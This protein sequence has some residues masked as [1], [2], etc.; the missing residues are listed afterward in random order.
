MR[1]ARSPAATV[2]RTG[3]SSIPMPPLRLCIL[4]HAHL[5]F[6]RR[7]EY[8]DPFEER[9]L[10]EAVAECYLPLLDAIDGW[11]RDGV[12]FGLTVSIS[13]TLA[14]MLDDPLLRSRCARRLT[15]S[16]E[17][18]EKE[19]ARTESD[20]ALAPLARAARDRAERLLADYES[21]WRRDVAG[22]F[23]SF[24]SAGAAG[25]IE[26]AGTCATH[27]FLPLMEG[28]PAAARAQTRIGARTHRDRFGAAPSGFWL[29]ECGFYP[30]ADALVAETG[31]R[32]F[33][34]DAHGLLASDPPPDYGV[35]VPCRSPAG[36]AIFARELRASRAV[37]DAKSGYPG[38]GRYLE[39]HRDVGYDLDADYLAPYIHESG[40]RIATGIKYRAIGSRD[41]PLGE[42]PVYDPEAAARAVA[43]HAAHFVAERVALARELAGL[44]DRPPVAVVPF[45]AELFGHWW[46]EGPAFLDAV[47]RGVA[48]ESEVRAATLADA[49]EASLDA[50][51]LPEAAPKTS[52]WGEGGFSAVWLD[53]SNAWIRPELDGAAA[54]F[55]AAARERAGT[56][57]PLARRA[58][59][60]AARELLLAQA[61]DWPFMIR[62]GTTARYAEERVREHVAAVRRTSLAAREGTVEEARLAAIEARDN[63]FP[64][65]EFEELSDSPL[66]PAT[67]P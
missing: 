13:P 18:A 48:R 63:L 32:W 24:R 10:H 59:N 2:F 14:A 65:L 19:C 66:R 55:R 60:Q 3:S 56:T 42:K 9:W 58:L 12:P 49:L 44:V 50:G 26:L 37:W 22:A 54:A 39:F 28:D 30:G 7:P 23:A 29:P 11:V 27:A 31:A 34:L 17:L 25:G 52:S 46:R 38:D 61:S 67:A 43:E 8:E 20:P 33:V 6:V 64:R 35:F 16:L 53:A 40:L 47:V 45:D 36:P 41:T 21:R 5:P 62:M 4:L 51:P 15:L 57:D 1:E